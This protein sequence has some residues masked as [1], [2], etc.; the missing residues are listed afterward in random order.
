[1]NKAGQIIPTSCSNDFREVR[2]ALGW[3]SHIP[4][5]AHRS[6]DKIERR[7]AELEAKLDKRGLAA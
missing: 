7:L 4:W 1:M 2:N 3:M 5:G 6:I